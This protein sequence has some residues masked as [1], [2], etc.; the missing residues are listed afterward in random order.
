MTVT[1]L[2]LNI[3]MMN[4]ST[5]GDLISIDEQT[6]MLKLIDFLLAAAAYYTR[7]YCTVCF[8]MQATALD[9]PVSGPSPW[10][11]RSGSVVVRF[12]F[13]EIGKLDGLGV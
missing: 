9:V 3:R 6:L 1:I 10:V 7:L 2:L 11:R 13:L 5:A 8:S 4:Q 12:F